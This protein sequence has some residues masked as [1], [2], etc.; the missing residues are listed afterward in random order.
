M[1]IPTS[2]QLLFMQR[3]GGGHT[4]S[5]SLKVL[6]P[7]QKVPP[8]QLENTNSTNRFIVWFPNIEE[9]HKIDM[10]VSLTGKTPKLRTFFGK[11]RVFV[12]KT[13]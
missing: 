7:W 11:E 13:F 1:G 12:F 2:V 3:Q 4:T 6:F 10:T 8:Q 5:L 9:S